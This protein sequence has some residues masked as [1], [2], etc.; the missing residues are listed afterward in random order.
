[1]EYN[2]IFRVKFDLILVMYTCINLVNQMFL[3]TVKQI[4][5]FDSSTCNCYKLI[6]NTAIV[7]MDRLVR[8]WSTFLR[9]I[10]HDKF[11]ANF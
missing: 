1:M 3:F 11:A 5:L 4:Y 9:A 10:N 6:A 7:V 8:V 2:A